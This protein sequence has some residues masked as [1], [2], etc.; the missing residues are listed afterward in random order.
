MNYGYKK[1]VNLPYAEAE[2]KVRE[3]LKKEGFGVITEID[4]KDTIK[5]KL[6]IDFTNYIILGAC[7]PQ[8]S[9]QALQILF[10]KK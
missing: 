8:F 5:K 3:E 1:Q 4:V 10:Y 6:N 9:H 7:N 2:K